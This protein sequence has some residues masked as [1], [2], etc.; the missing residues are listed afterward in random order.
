MLPDLLKVPLLRLT[1]RSRRKLQR[2]TSEFLRNPSCVEKTWPL[3][4]RRTRETE[5][6][7]WE[8]WENWEASFRLRSF[9]NIDSRFKTGRPAAKKRELRG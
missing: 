4:P 2:R 7:C 1:Q 9:R 8:N 3:P 6:L 5:R